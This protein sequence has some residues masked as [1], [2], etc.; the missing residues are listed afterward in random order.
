VAAVNEGSGGNP[1]LADMLADTA[2]TTLQ[3]QEQHGHNGAGVAPR[4]AQNE[5]FDGSPDEVFGS[6]G[7]PR[8][9]GSSYWADLAFMPTKKPA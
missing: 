1:I 7:R 4:A 6:G 3:A 9:D 5:Q 8:G 2:V